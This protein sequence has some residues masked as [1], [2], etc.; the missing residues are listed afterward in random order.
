MSPNAQ[1]VAAFLGRG[2]DTN[3]VAL[4]G[5]HLPL[6]TE[7]ARVHTRGVG[8]DELDNP[9]DAIAAVITSAT[10]RLV[11][12]PELLQSEQIGDYS[13]RYTAFQGWSILERAVLDAYRRKAA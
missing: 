1:A 3:L 4:A 7:M 11:N 6:I 13:A 2:D 8:F 5:E 12:N 9:N 10:A